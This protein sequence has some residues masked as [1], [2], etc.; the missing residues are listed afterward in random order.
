MR[1]FAVR[2]LNLLL[3]LALYALG[4]VV[5][6]WANVG[7]GP[8]EVFHMGLADKIGLS[9]GAASMLAGA[10]VLVIALAMGETLGLGTFCNI[11]VIGLFIDFFMSLADIKAESFFAGII[12][13]IA[14][15]F[16]ISL[17]SFFYIRSGFGA[18]PRDSL[19]VALTRKTK[20]PVGLCRSAVELTAAFTGWLMGGM[21]G[22]GTV[23]SFLAIGACI[24]ITFA[25]LKFDVKAVKHETVKETLLNLRD[26]VLRKQA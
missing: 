19:M 11:V 22:A 16:I 2:L 14:G 7:Y 20:K 10:A 3:G 1:V 15:M 17:G 21:V 5:T 23:I 6:V 4:I 8:W 26:S 13:L 25:L 18:G 12:M 9:L 24:Q